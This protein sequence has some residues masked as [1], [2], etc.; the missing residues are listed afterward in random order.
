MG[1]DRLRDICSRCGQTDELNK[2]DEC[3]NCAEDTT[4][5]ECETIREIYEASQ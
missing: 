4:N 5:E 1:V 2:D 3:E